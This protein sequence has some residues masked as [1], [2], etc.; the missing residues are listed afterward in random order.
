MIT[1]NLSTLKIHKLTQEQYDRELANGRIDENALYMTPDEEIDLSPYATVEQLEGKADAEHSHD[2]K[3]YT[4][5]EI[6]SK[7][8]VKANKA[9]TL[10]G[11]GITDAASKEYVDTIIE[12]LTTEGTADA[13]LVQ[14]NLTA[15][16]QDKNNPH[17]M[18]LKQLDI[19]VTSAELNFTSGVT[20]NI[21][22]QLNS[23]A[24]SSHAHDE[25]YYSK[26]EIDNKL[27]SKADVSA[28]PDALADL[29]EDASHRTVT[30]AEKQAWNAKSTF[31]GKYEDLTGKPDL[32][33]KTYVD[34][35]DE[36]V[37]S[38]AKGYTDEQ[39]AL[40]LNN[41]SEAVDSI[42]ELANAMATNEGVV[43][44]LKAAVGNKADKTHSHDEQYY[45][46]TEIDTKM[47]DKAP[48]G[49]GLGTVAKDISGTDLLDTLKSAKSGLYRGQNVTNAPSA[50]WYY[51]QVMCD[52]S[53]YS[54][55]LAYRYGGVIYKASLSETNGLSQW[56]KIYDEQN[57]L[58]A[59]DVGAMPIIDANGVEGA[60]DNPDMDAILKSGVHY[61]VYQTN[62]STVG[63]PYYY[64][65]ITFSNVQRALIVSYSGKVGYGFQIAM[66]NGK[67]F[68]LTRSCFNNTIS[69]WQRYYNAA[70]VDAIVSDL[71]D[72]IDDRAEKTH[73]HDIADVNSLQS[74]LD[75]KS[76]SDHTHNYA[77]SSS[78]GGA[79]TSANKVNKSLTVKLNSGTTE[80][81]NMFTFNGSTAKSFDITASAVGAAAASHS[82]NDTYYTETEVDT[83]LGEKAPT[84][85]ASTATTYGKATS[86]NYG[87]VK[88]SDST[89]ST[90]GVSGGIAATPAAVKAVYD[91]LNTAKVDKV[92]GKG[93]STN[94]YTTAEKTK[95]SGIE[96]NANNYTLPVATSSAIGGVKSG[97]DITVDSSGNVS[98]NDDS[99]NHII[100][101]VDNLQS[102]LDKKADNSSHKINTYTT[103][104]DIGLSD[105]DMVA[106]D[107]N[108]FSTNITKIVYACPSSAFMMTI[109][110][111]STTNVNFG[112]S[113]R[114][115]LDADLGTDYVN[116]GITVRCL[117][118]SFGG[119]STPGK[120][121][122]VCD[123]SDYSRIYTAQ[124]DGWTPT[125]GTAGIYVRPFIMSYTRSGFL[126]L[127]GGTLVGDTVKFKNGLSK[128]YTDASLVQLSTYNVADTTANSS[129]LQI[130]NNESSV[131]STLRLVDYDA[132]G[133]RTDY[134]VYGQHNKPTAADVGVSNENLLDNWYWLDPINS[135]GQTSYTGSYAFDRWHCGTNASTVAWEFV[136][137]KG[138][139]VTNNGTSSVYI[140]QRT[141]SGYP[142]GKYTF[143]ILVTE[144]TNNVSMYMS[145][146]NGNSVGSSLKTVSST[147]L[148]TV[149]K[150]VSNFYRV[151]FTI[152]AGASVTIAAVKLECGSVQ[153]FAHQD[154]D[155]NWVINDCPPNKHMETLKCIQSTAVVND[156]YANKSICSYT[157]GTA[158][159]T[160]GTSELAAGT[161]YFVYE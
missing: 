125:G 88:L 7:L 15:H 92:D 127:D 111:G 31:S 150:D 34:D 2:D 155:G 80:G 151:Q 32:I 142:N 152:P 85:H 27:L 1:E 17:G 114:A 13:A 55:V 45:T 91:A 89:S 99:H 8:S 144:I 146:N 112:N 154:A 128:I 149:T 98:V 87:H 10:E 35:Q 107:E 3:Y 82:H 30:D 119:T 54:T 121:E 37:L 140:R 106:E 46:E 11:Y 66:P 148:H 28:I 64:D 38:D 53:K 102:T 93:L 126:P 90:S 83:K 25:T 12:G 40:L 57:P 23:K 117:I 76:N 22:D 67:D 63:T 21:Q 143:S 97:T 153:T 19:D 29:T 65:N 157:Y 68:M 56:Y 70:E 42:M 145:N 105:S 131:A 74:T 16:T 77:G 75:G 123:H 120:I 71:E 104:S 160:E 86:S 108:S 118:T 84:S 103:L 72:A 18:T 59:T 122:V 115:K 133:K 43:E 158:D 44:A 60:T 81:T 110:G 26:T 61:G 130:L 101:N 139:K 132:D 47:L 9:T 113:L 73:T 41:S 137:G 50:S 62:G 141:E 159:L 6:D 134:L 161:L 49:F 51:F 135:R 52:N 94:D 96:A 58:N 116:K 138:I 79:A 100:S 95:L 129:H 33:S 20:S 124:F 147:G 14:A 136:E 48:A 4:E 39:I 36:S 78:A 69:S 5:T 109:V 156:T 24:N